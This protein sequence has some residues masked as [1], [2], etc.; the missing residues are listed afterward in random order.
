MLLALRAALSKLPWQVWFAVAIFSL[1]P[2]SYCK[3]KHDGKQVIIE[4]LE[5]AE[6]KAKKEAVKAAD[7]ADTK[8]EAAQVA[9]DIEQKIIREAIDEEKANGGNA[10]DAL[11]NSL[12]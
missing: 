8:Q 5:Q 7:K 9:F 1:I 10:L 2:L 11:F 4:R 3:G 6:V 12:P